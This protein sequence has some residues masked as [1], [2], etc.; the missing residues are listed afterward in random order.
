MQLA[1][2]YF[3]NPAQLVCRILYTYMAAPCCFEDLAGKILA[4]LDKSAK[5]TKILHCTLFVTVPSVWLA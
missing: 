3:V 2:K 4:G 5:S 1:G